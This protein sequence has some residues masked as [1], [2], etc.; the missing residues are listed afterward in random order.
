MTTRIL[1]FVLAALFALSGAV[2]QAHVPPVLNDQQSVLDRNSRSSQDDPFEMYRCY[3]AVDSGL[4]D[5]SVRPVGAL[6]LGICLLP[7]PPQQ[8]TPNLAIEV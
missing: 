7:T 4:L 3:S 2:A 6:D 1:T 8:I 5:S